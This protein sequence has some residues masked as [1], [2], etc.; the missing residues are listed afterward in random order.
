MLNFSSP[1][2]VK[3]AEFPRKSILLASP[4]NPPTRISTP[5]PS[6]S[7]LSVLPMALNDMSVLATLIPLADAYPLFCLRI[8]TAELQAIHQFLLKISLLLIDLFLNRFNR[9]S[10]NVSL[11]IQTNM[12]KAISRNGMWNGKIKSVCTTPNLSLGQHPTD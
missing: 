3:L 12:H 6:A 8:H 11:I 4:P 2:D 1:C 10:S 7:P 9:H 5:C